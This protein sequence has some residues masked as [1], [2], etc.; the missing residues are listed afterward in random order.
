MRQYSRTP[1][2]PN[3][4][5]TQWP[6]ARACEDGVREQRCEYYLTL[7]HSCNQ[8]APFGVSKGRKD[9]RGGVRLLSE[10]Y[11]LWGQGCAPQKRFGTP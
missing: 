2:V 10:A 9:T 4:A 7:L 11:P 1:P 5:R 3:P 6:R 8:V